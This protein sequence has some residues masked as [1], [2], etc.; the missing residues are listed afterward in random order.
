MR[1]KQPDPDPLALAIGA[2]RRRERSE[3]ELREWL[4]DRERFTPEQIDEAVAELVEAG[5][6]DDERFARLFAEDKRELS[7]WGPERIREALRKRRIDEGLIER[8]AE[9]ESHADQIDRAER[10]LAGRG[11]GLEDDKARNRALG[12][13]TRRGYDY[14]VAYSAIRRLAS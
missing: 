5:E 13:L 2:L 4:A 14:E 8:Y 10:L 3:A 7:G 6:I 12:Y 9:A 11:A 1:P